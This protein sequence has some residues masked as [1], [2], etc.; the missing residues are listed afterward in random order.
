MSLRNLIAGILVLLVLS[1][2]LFAVNPLIAS[3]SNSG[4]CPGS[5][6]NSP[7]IKEWSS[8][9]DG[10]W[11]PE[12]VLPTGSS[13]IRHLVLVN[14]PISSKNVLITQGDDGGL[15]A[16][17]CSANCANPASW[18]VSINIGT[19]VTDLSGPIPRRFDVE[20][21]TAT[22]N[23]VVVYSVANTLGTRD[24]AYKVLPAA[25]N[26]FAGLPERYIDDTGH[27]G[28]ISYS[29]VSLD[30]KPTTGS[31]QMVLAAQDKT[32]QD[33]N[34]WVW[35]GTGWGSQTEISSR[36]AGGNTEMLAV[37]YTNDGSEAM[38]LGE[39]DVFSGPNLVNR[40]INYKYWTGSWSALGSFDPIPGATTDA[41]EWITLKANYASQKDLQ[42]V[43]T[44][45]IPSLT[46]IFWNGAAWT[47]MNVDPSTDLQS[48]RAAD[49]EWDY[50]SSDMPPPV[51]TGKLVWDT[52]GPPGTMLSYRA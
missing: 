52:D 7:K 37:K 47:T 32:D 15:D 29:W 16:Y 35:S 30:R 12:V 41:P 24:L 22:G 18:T 23:A 51:N 46:T 5:A 8:A 10:S 20:F 25:S 14:S 17:V 26:S 13:T 6:M 49:F 3:R 2:T 31:F 34:A 44:S 4:S 36:T 19:V 11:G 21:E 33:I 40:V 43:A 39:Y 28:D 38:V 42:G 45:S 50:Q 48:H 1:D 27:S 9:G